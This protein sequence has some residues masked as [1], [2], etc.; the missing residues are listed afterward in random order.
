M[1]AHYETETEISASHQ[2]I[3]QLPDNI[4]PDKAKVAITYEIAE[5]E[6]SQDTLMA[7]FLTSLPD[8][9]TGGLSRTEIQTYLNQER[10]A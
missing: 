6:T 8:N 1:Q 5:T 7:D 3:L 2:L 4:P 10:Q 9:P